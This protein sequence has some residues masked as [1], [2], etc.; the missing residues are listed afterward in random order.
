MLK[1]YDFDCLKYAFRGLDHHLAPDCCHRNLTENRIWLC[2]T[3][4][5]NKQSKSLRRKK[6]KNSGAAAPLKISR[7]KTTLSVW[8]KNIDF[9]ILMVMLL[10]KENPTTK[11]KMNYSFSQKRLFSNKQTNKH[12]TKKHWNLKNNRQTWPAICV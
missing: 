5:L 12:N 4:F 3:N 8:P 10:L 6:S 7:E 1:N 2:I 9:V 11:Q